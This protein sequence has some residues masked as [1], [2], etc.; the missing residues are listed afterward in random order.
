MFFSH[1]YQVTLVLL[2]LFIPR[3]EC[4]GGS[5]ITMLWHFYMAI[6]KNHNTTTDLM[7]IILMWLYFQVD[8]Y[9]IRHLEKNFKSTTFFLSEFWMWINWFFHFINVS[10]YSKSSNILTH[11]KN[12]STDSFYIRMTYNFMK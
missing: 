1:F 9:R 11:P 5:S 4:G 7:I 10:W 12:L 8:F 3:I 6:V 2:L